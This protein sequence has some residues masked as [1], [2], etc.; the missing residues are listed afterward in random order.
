MRDLQQWLA[1]EPGRR[2][3][4]QAGLRPVGDPVDSASFVAAGAQRDTIARR[5][6]SH[7]PRSTRRGTPPRPR[8]SPEPGAHRPRRVRVDE[9]DGAARPGDA[10]AGRR[11]RLGRLVA[12]VRGD[13]EVGLWL[14]PADGSG[15]G[16][17]R[18][19]SVGPL[20]DLR[21]GAIADVL[22]QAA[23]S[24]KTPL[25]D[26]TAEGVVELGP[27][28]RHRRH[29]ADRHHRRGGHH[30]HARSRRPARR[31]PRGQV[32]V[33]VITIGGTSCAARPL[34]S[35]TADT[36]GACYAE[37]P[38]A[39]ARASPRSSRTRGGRRCCCGANPATGPTSSGSPSPCSC[40][41][42]CSPG[43]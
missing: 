36:G 43:S 12:D 40:A 42:A 25:F 10:P 41:W 20:D 7:R 5:P 21:R 9:R 16:V 17:R 22:E 18:E 2:A 29:Q 3:L 39:S 30:E 13:D 24:G 8:P 26:A 4:E 31:R 28:R 35:L 23:P 38:P 32:R 34:E 14:F 19:V 37:V 27:Q 11:R 33:F 6:S 15:R 1:D